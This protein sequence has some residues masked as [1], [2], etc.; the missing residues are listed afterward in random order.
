MIIGLMYGYCVNIKVTG[1][2][3][4]YWVKYYICYWV[5]IRLLR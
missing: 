3:Y 2:M 4:G 5:N 1:L